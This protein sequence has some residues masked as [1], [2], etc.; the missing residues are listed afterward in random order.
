[1]KLFKTIIFGAVAAL[2]TVQLAAADELVRRPADGA[3]WLETPFGVEAAPVDGD[4]S[5]GKHISLIRFKAGTRTP[6]HTHSAAYVGVVVQGQ[7]IHFE[8]GTDGE[9]TALAPGSS[10]SV[11]AN[12]PHV[13]G[14]LAGD[15]CIFALYQ[16]E[17]FDFVPLD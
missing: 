1:M 13:S 5:A 4:F 7:G 10:W 15:D 2:A 17:A 6:V 12:L 14:C 3:A 9:E 8:P 11:P 16:D